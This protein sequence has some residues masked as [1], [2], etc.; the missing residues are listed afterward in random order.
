MNDAF[1]G[2][3]CHG[4]RVAEENETKDNLVAMHES[5][6][7]MLRHARIQNGAHPEYQNGYA[8]GFS[9]ANCLKP[10]TLN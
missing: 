4:F 1:D 6:D 3:P 7:A 9:R 2:R 5:E 10:I 8:R